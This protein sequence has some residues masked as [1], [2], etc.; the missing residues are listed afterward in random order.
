MEPLVSVRKKEFKTAIA[1]PITI[2]DSRFGI[3]KIYL[4]PNEEPSIGGVPQRPGRG[5]NGESQN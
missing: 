2:R 3:R 1:K 4:N 5:P